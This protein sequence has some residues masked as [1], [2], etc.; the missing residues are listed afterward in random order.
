MALRDDTTRIILERRAAFVA[1]ALATLA[2][3]GQAVSPRNLAPAASDSNNAA[4]ASAREQSSH[5]VATAAS[6]GSSLERGPAST[7]DPAAAPVA[8]ATGEL[9]VSRPAV[10]MVCLSIK[11]QPS[12]KFATGQVRIE[13]SQHLVL[14][15]LAKLL[16]A[17]PQV[18]L[19]LRGH[20][21][22]REDR[23]GLRLGKQRAVA[24]R[25]YLIAKGVDPSRLC[26]SGLGNTMPIAS[27]E[28]AA[29][30]ASNRR[31]GFRPLDP[32][33]SC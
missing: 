13:P 27:N 20:T 11:I 16:A 19:Q 31:V 22:D 30:R 32:N 5:P 17:R 6:T 8:S 4:T 29:G 15:E 10:A 3:C 12:A 33:E 1:A 9:V 7:S 26:V 14:D 23:Y 2:G 18:R 28:T 25:Q 24:V 21:D